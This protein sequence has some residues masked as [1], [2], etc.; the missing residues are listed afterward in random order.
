[1]WNSGSASLTSAY[2]NRGEQ[3]SIV[4]RRQQED[5]RLALHQDIQHNSKLT[6]KASWEHKTSK[7]ITNN[8]IQ[9]HARV[10][11]QQSEQLLQARRQK[12]AELLASDDQLYRQE[13]VSRQETSTQKAKRLILHARKLKEEREERRQRFAEEMREKQWRNG[14]D[15]LRTLDGEYYRLHINQ[16]VINQQNDK[17]IKNQ[18]NNKR[19]PN[20]LRYGNVTD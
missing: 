6:H 3:R 4:Q 12:L 11:A 13:I 16:E 14:C 19:K 5:S 17:K 20:G 15:D 18:Y 7:L 8:Q 10:K 1:M 2:S 9:N